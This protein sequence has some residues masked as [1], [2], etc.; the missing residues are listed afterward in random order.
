MLLWFPLCVRGERVRERVSERLHAATFIGSTG[1]SCKVWKLALTSLGSLWVKKLLHTMPSFDE[2]LKEAGEFGRFQKRVFFLLC[3]TG[4]TFSFLFVGVVFLGHTPEPYWCR[5]PGAADVSKKCGWTLEE[6]KNL[7]VP[8]LNL[9]NRSSNGQCERFDIDWN[10]ISV[11][12]ANPL[13][14]FT[15]SSLGSVP[16]TTCQN[17]W[18]YRHP[19]SSVVSEVRTIKIFWSVFSEWVQDY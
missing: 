8:S 2:V 5:I 12:C 15:N 6:E 10:N 9:V 1:S 11:S 13:A 14:H 17:G 3:Q 18:V 16:L 7:T 19:H 4:I